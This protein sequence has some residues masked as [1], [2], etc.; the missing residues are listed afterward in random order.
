MTWPIPRFSNRR[1]LTS[2]L[3]HQSLV[4]CSSFMHRIKFETV[5]LHHLSRGRARQQL[6]GS[7]WKITVA[8]ILIGGMYALVAAGG[9]FGG[10]LD[11]TSSPDGPK[12]LA[13]ALVTL[14]VA[15]LLSLGAAVRYFLRRK[16]TSLH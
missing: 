5:G 15:A 8:S 11:G 16:P 9:G 2:V 7:L 14:T 1:L 4:E 12:A 3:R 10:P 6:L 13:V